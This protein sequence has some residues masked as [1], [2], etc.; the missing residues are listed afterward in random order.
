MVK[1]EGNKEAESDE[2]EGGSD[3][4]KSEVGMKKLRR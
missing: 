4:E 2:P 3:I 1:Y